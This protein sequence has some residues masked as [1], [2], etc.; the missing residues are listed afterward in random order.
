MKLHVAV[1]GGGMVSRVHLEALSQH[2]AVSAVSLA[3]STPELL[4]QM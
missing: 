2:P 3:E 1:I 4:H